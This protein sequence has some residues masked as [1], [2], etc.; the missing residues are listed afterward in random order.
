MNKSPYTPGVSIVA[1][2]YNEELTI[3]ENVR[4]LLAQEYPV[5]EV[6][7]VNDGSKDQTLEKLIE[8]FSLVEVPYAYVAQIKTQPYKGCLNPHVWNMPG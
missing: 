1:P 7:I 5:F 4:S 6:I 8:Y 3:V 2:A